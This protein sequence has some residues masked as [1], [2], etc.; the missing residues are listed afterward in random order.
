MIERRLVDNIIDNAGPICHTCAPTIFRNFHAF[1]LLCMQI[2]SPRTPWHALF[3]KLFYHA[4]FC[5]LNICAVKNELR[6]GGKIRYVYSRTLFVSIRH[7]YFYFSTK[8]LYLY[9]SLISC[10]KNLWKINLY[11]DERQKIAIVAF[12]E[13]AIT[14]V[15]GSNARF[16]IVPLAEIVKFLLTTLLLLYWFIGL[17]VALRGR[18]HGRN[19]SSFKDQTTLVKPRSCDK[20]LERSTDSAVRP[21]DF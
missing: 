6:N 14:C 1:S 21:N 16:G 7:K 10:G 13:S 8:Y 4:S 3:S 11:E 20:L 12:N 5:V 9:S 18:K 15:L 19:K 2:S 17:M